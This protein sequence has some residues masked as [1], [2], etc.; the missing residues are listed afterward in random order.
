MR[1]RVAAAA[2]VGLIAAT[3]AGCAS[4]TGGAAV[5]TDPD[6]ITVEV[7]SRPPFTLR[8]GQTLEWDLFA[9]VVTERY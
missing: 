6:A 3:T 1:R 9:N 5:S 8:P 7:T 4:R 2:L